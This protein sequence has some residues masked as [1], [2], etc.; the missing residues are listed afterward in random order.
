[1]LRQRGYGTGFD[2]QEKARSVHRLV[3]FAPLELFR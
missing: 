2:P 1:L 3:H